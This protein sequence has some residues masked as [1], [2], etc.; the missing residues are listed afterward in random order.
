MEERDL[1][2][3]KLDGEVARIPW[4]KRIYIRFLFMLISLIKVKAFFGDFSSGLV[5]RDESYI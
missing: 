1:R 5:L 3:V 4:L 2:D